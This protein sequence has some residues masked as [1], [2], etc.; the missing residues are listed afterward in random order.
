MIEVLRY[1]AP[2]IPDADEFI[3]ELPD[4]LEESVRI[5]GVPWLPPEAGHAVDAQ[6]RLIERRAPSAS[7]AR[8]SS[9]PARACRTPTT[10]TMTVDDEDDDDED[11]DLEVPDDDEEESSG[12]RHATRAIAPTR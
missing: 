10:T 2:L 1:I 8:G 7:S 3:D 12:V 9:R 11:D 4:D 5:L 6:R